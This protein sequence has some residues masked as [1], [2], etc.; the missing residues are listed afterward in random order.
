MIYGKLYDLPK[1][2]GDIIHDREQDIKLSQ[3]PE[4]EQESLDAE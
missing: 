2:D 3:G 4:I 1:D